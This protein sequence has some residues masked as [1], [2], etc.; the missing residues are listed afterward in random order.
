[1]KRIVALLLSLATACWAD[2]LLPED[3]SDLF[4]PNRII[5]GD[6][7]TVVIED[8][9]ATSQQVAVQNRSNS[10]VAN[11]ILNLVGAITGIS[12]DHEDQN[13]RDETA[14]SNSQYSETITATVVAVDGNNLSLQ[15]SSQITL[16][17]KKRGVTLTGKVRRRDIGA[18]N[19]V[20]SLYLADAEVSV[21]GIH[22]SP[23]QPGIV[24]QVLRFLF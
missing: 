7:V 22:R 11:P 5:V 4:A 16:D 19:K 2:S 1:M 24:T 6:L 13:Q 9:V 21:D 12:P 8:R 3:P 10:G 14:T 17:G 15:A 18:D 23:V 20:S